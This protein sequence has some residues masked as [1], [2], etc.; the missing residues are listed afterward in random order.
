[1]YFATNSVEKPPVIP[2]LGYELKFEDTN[3]RILC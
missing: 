1:M 2:Y 3:R